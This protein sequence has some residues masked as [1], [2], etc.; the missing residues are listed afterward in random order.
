MESK[1]LVELYAISPIDGRYK[2]KISILENY[3]SE[4]ALFK[5]RVQVEI[6]YF[7]ALSEIGLPQF[8]GFPKETLPTLTGIYRNFSAEDALAIKRIEARTNHDV[9]AV[10]Y[11][12]RDKFQDL[13]LEE[14]LEFI[15]FG[16]TSQDVNNTALPL[17]LKEA[18][19]KSIRPIF[20]NVIEMLMGM[21]AS[22][23]YN[24]PMMAFT[25]GQ[26]ATPTHLG[27]E[28]RVF[29]ERLKVVLASVDA[30]PF[31]AKFGG[32]TGGLNAHQL[33]FPEVD[34]IV[35]SNK[36]VSERLGLERTQWTTQIEPYDH[37]AAF[38]NGVSQLNNI[39]IDLARDVWHYI[40]IAYFK[41]RKIEG[42][43]GSSA[44]PHKVNPIDF[45]NAEGN[46]GIA[47]AL[48][49]HFANK[50]PVSRLQ[51]DLTDSTVLRN[52]GVPL[53]HTLIALKS[54]EKGLGK[55]FPD[56]KRI[57]EDLAGH[58]ELLAEAIQTILRK[59]NYPNAYDV[60]KGLTRGN[61]AISL[62]DLLNFIA[63][64]NLPQEEK[65]KL[66]ELRPETYS[67]VYPE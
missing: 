65:H 52:I 41:Q 5:Y 19:R 60:L 61:E 10:E 23:D 57:S 8:E 27:K 34:W 43:V 13:G 32:A 54:L 11:F 31:R 66:M 9:K 30:I 39:L 21:S 33:A 38:C 28:I 24:I 40:S 36:L 20:A 51:R 25:H 47:N 6:E 29:A 16:L 2:S 4:F 26:P 58:P 7:I 35:F 18:W 17:S 55:I 15:H 59:H 12:L 14:W 37:I 63:N 62:N 67:G 53:G 49:G 22:K 45:E 56:Q 1:S 50:L 44:M 64:L 46:L 48:F 42:E 3:F